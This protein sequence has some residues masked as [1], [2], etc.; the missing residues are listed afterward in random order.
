MEPD[1]VLADHRVGVLP[2]HRGQ[3]GHH[4]G[5][6]PLAGT[7]TGGLRLGRIGGVVAGPL[8]E[9]LRH[10]AGGETAAAPT[11]ARAE[12]GP[13][14]GEGGVGGG[15][16]VVDLADDGIGRH[17]GVRQEHLVEHGVAGH[18]HQRPD[19]DPFL[20]HVARHPGDPLVLGGVR[21]GAG[22]QHAHV[23]GLTERR[24]HLL[25]VDDPFL[26]VELGPGGEPGQVG[27]GARLR[28][29]LTPGLLAGDD[30]SHVPVDLLL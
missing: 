9:H 4:R 18:L 22:D 6:G 19:V 2:D 17:P 10:G 26:A 8:V 7:L 30:L 21:V 1:E 20:V 25:T 27:T 29:E 15:P 12:T 14:V 11:A 13:L 5:A 24:P 23:G 28:E 16:T 3:V